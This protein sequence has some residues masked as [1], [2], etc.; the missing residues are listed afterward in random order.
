MQT[1]LQTR[2]QTPLALVS[3]VEQDRQW[4]K[5]KLGVNSNEPL[6]SLASCMHAIYPDNLG[7]F[8]V[9]YAALDEQFKCNDLSYLRTSYS[10]LCRS[11]SVLSGAEGHF[12]EPWYPVYNLLET[13]FNLQDVSKQLFL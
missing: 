9:N 6:R 1:R 8:V 7:V 4:F 11:P 2:L 12:M 10:I 13:T 5:S 3:L